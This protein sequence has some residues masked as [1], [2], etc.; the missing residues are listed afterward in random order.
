MK[1]WLKKTKKNIDSE[2]TKTFGKISKMN[3][4]WP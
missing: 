1:L 4:L 2:K 3:N